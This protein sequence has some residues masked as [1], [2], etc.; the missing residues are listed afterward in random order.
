MKRRWRHKEVCQDNSCRVPHCFSS[1]AIL[2]HYR[3]CRD[4][5]CPACGPVRETVRKAAKISTNSTRSDHRQSSS[6]N[7]MQN[8]SNNIFS[9]D[10]RMSTSSTPPHDHLVS[11]ASPDPIAPNIQGG[12]YGTSSM[13][14]LPQQP[15]QRSSTQSSSM[16]PPVAAPLASSGMQY[17]SS[18]SSYR[19]NTLVANNAPKVA[20]S[21]YNQNVET[22]PKSMH[23]NDDVSPSL[24]QEAPS[25]S[26]MS[27]LSVPSG[28]RNW[29]SSE[30]PKILHKQQRLRLLR[31][32]STCQHVG[33][34]P[35]TPLCASM[36]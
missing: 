28:S 20:Q 23:R 4:S 7:Q 26:V 1:R 8:Q 33:D 16:P 17:Q 29:D 12:S 15:Q 9:I 31:H 2:S 22:L 34:Y 5:Q 6:S 18:S 3:K 36:K 27:S 11:S 35:G 10:S 21:L 13:N 25:H 19:P 30:W 32:S 14:F 24:T